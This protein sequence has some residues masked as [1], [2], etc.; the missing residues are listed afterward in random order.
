MA[1]V[2]PPPTRTYILNKLL[3][4]ELEVL[5]ARCSY[6]A[7]DQAGYLDDVS[8]LLRKCRIRARTTHDLAEQAMWK[9][10]GARMALIVASQLVEMKVKFFFLF[11][12]FKFRSTY[13]F[14]L[15]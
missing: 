9:E 15:V 13:I 2:E 10:R 1:V 11:F 12:G 14:I 7:G 6:W 3:P 5:R 4:F 8:A